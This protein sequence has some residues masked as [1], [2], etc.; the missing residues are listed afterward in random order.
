MITVVEVD[1]PMAFTLRR[2]ITDGREEYEVAV[3]GG[4]G[5]IAVEKTVT[6]ALEALNIHRAL[7]GYDPR[8]F[9][10][11]EEIEV[12]DLR[13]KVQVGPIEGSSN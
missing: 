6:D 10:L 11:Q 4:F 2:V 8:H 3:N 1:K 9:P 12:L 7:H 13:F 5:I